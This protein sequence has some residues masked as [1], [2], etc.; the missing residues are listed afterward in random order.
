MSVD[1]QN[2]LATMEEAIGVLLDHMA[3]SKVARVLAAWQIG[4]GDYLKLREKLFEGESVEKLFKQAE[5]LETN[6]SDV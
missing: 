1:V 6:A 4:T 2:E 3:P 5:A